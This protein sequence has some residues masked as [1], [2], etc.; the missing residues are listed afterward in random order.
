MATIEARRHTRGAGMANLSDRSFCIS[1][2]MPELGIRQ[3]YA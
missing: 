1:F 2:L 3:E